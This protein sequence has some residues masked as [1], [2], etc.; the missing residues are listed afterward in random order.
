MTIEDVKQLNI[1]KVPGCYLYSNEE[2]KIIYVGKA[3]NLNSRVLSYWQKAAEH[4]LAKELMLT[5]I[6]KIEWIEAGSEIEALLLE[7]NLIKKYQPDFN[8][9]QRDDKRYTYIKISTEE[10]WPRVFMTRQLDKAGRYFGPFVSTEA[11]RETLKVIRKIW[12]FRSCSVMPKKAC[13][14]YRIGKCP[15]VCENYLDKKDYNRIIKQIILFLEGKRNK[16]TKDLGRQI[17]EL[18][19]NGGD[20]KKLSLLKYQLLNMRRVLEHSNVLSLID[21]YSSDVIELAKVLNLDRVPARIEGYDISNIFGQE[22]VGSMVVFNDGEADKNQYRKFKIKI[23]PGQANDIGMLK[24]IVER[25]FN[26]DWPLP[27]LI[28]VDGG[29]G[30]L[31]AILFV[32]AKRKLDITAIAVSKGE[33]LRSALAPDKIFFPGESKPLELPLA[34]PALHIIKRVRDE[35][36]RFAIK[37]HRELRS[38]KLKIVRRN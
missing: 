22:A 36:H 29:R 31:N 10:E 18:E 11:V 38:K 26:N 20:Q 19:K 5:K 3:A 17:K 7:S 13:L 30:Q 34:S 16:I 35:A 23:N 37:Y 21:K 25:R 24:E 2:G 14:Y 6:K 33:G 12:P 1:P 27:D 32:L 15:G 4:T 28:I 9:V 8:I